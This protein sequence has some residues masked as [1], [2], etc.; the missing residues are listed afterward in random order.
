MPR[1]RAGAEKKKARKFNPRFDPFRNEKELQEDLRRK[2]N[3]FALLYYH[4]HNSKNSPKGFPDA[5]IASPPG[6]VPRLLVAELKTPWNPNPTLSQRAWLDL[7]RQ[8]ADVVN[9]AC[10]CTMIDVFLWTHEELDEL[11]RT[12]AWVATG[13]ESYLGQR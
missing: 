9:A 12:L 4:T 5:M 3:T 7:Y 11:R 6:A 2:C 1:W 10:G 8:L 13:K